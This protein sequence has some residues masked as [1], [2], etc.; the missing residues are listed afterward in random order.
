[1]CAFPSPDRRFDGFPAKRV[2]QLDG[3]LVDFDLCLA[4]LH[5]VFDEALIPTVILVHYAGVEF[6]GA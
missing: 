6:F 5:D 3:D 4:V 2:K 1:V